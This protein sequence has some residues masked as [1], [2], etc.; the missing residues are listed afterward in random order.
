[1]IEELIADQGTP[2]WFETFK[3]P[4]FDSQGHILGTAGYAR[5][6]T[7]R[8]QAEKRL[9]ESRERLLTATAA[10]Q[11]G[12]YSIAF[13]ADEIYYSPQFL[14]HHGLGADGLLELD[15]DMVPR[16]IHPDD[17]PELVSRMRT[18][19]TPGGDGV[20]DHE[21][22]IIRPDGAIR[23]LRLVGRTVFS[24]D[25]GPPRPLR[26]AGILQDLSERK[27]MEQAL[28]ASRAQAVA[29]NAEKTTLLSSVAHEFRTP[30]SLLY[31]SLD[32][33]ERYGTRLTQ[34]QR[35]TQ[36]QYLRNAANQLKHLVDTTLA[37]NK[38]GVARP[39]I[40]PTPVD[41]AELCATICREVGSVWSRDHDFQVEISPQIGSML[42]DEALFRRVVENLLTNAFLY[43]PQ[44]GHIRFQAGTTNDQLCLEVKDQGPGIADED[45]SRIF[46][47]FFRGSNV[48]TNRGL[49]LGLNIVK[50]T[51]ERLGGHISLTSQLDRGTTFR[52][53]LP[54][55]PNNR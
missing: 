45:L 15:A 30:I 12:V 13:K 39:A 49:G 5:D 55:E 36:R 2:K 53:L 18:A 24:D 20:I 29:A 22:R 52:V 21:Y 48:G 37:F 41:L 10:A 46:D 32:I 26:S 38:T 42:I 7:Q 1:I 44:G 23:W 33:L 8:R 34:E 16:M 14:A 6:I 11:L 47:A 31:S 9:L 3:A 4:V 40:K 50:T 28:R 19:N 54:L 17:K 35:R 25:D 43:T 27:E 51:V